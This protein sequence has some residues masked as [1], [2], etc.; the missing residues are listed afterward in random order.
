[1]EKSMNK[2]S[3]VRPYFMDENKKIGNK[4]VKFHVCK[5]KDP[6]NHNLPCGRA[7]KNGPKHGTSSL[8]RHLKSV[9]PT[10]VE[11]LRIY[12]NFLGFY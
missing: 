1:M 12:K 8:L 9:H 6:E 4:I 2:G 10:D 5:V 3:W 11:I 7:F